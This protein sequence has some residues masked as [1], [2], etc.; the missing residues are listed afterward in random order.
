MQVPPASVPHLCIMQTLLCIQ[1]KL[2]CLSCA[3]LLTAELPALVRKKLLWLMRTLPSSKN[4]M[5]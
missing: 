1:E 3:S 2:N 4:K 5:P